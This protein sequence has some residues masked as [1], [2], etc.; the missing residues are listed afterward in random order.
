MIDGNGEEALP[1]MSKQ[2]TAMHI[3]DKLAGLL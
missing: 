3:V 2:E 1:L